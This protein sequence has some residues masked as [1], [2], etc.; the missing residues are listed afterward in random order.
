MFPINYGDSFPWEKIEDDETVWMVDFSLQPFE[1]MHKLSKMC[2][3]V[4]IDHHKSAI[5]QFNKENNYFRD[6]S[7][8][9]NN[10]ACELVWNYIN[11]PLPMP[12]SVYLL[13]RFDIWKHHEVPNSLEFQYGMKMQNEGPED[14]CW[15]ILLD[16]THF[17]HTAFIGD[18]IQQGK[19]IYNYEQMK[20]RE[21][22]KHFAFTSF[23]EGYRVIAVNQ[24]MTNSLLFDSIYDDN[25]HDI[26]MPFC[27]RDGKWTVSL[28]TKKNNIDVS[29]LAKKHGGGGHKGAAGFQCETLPI[30]PK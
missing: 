1:Q 21:F 12:K 17:L 14:E 27:F 20:N 18:I 24:G 26:M 25:L 5:E 30:G 19:L 22:V 9:S 10:A 2:E 11:S 16:E 13:G 29:I 15:K 28:Y 23:F 3:L 6:Y 8:D 7:L 4:W